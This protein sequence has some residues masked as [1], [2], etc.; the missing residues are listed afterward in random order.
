MTTPKFHRPITETALKY[1]IAAFIL[2]FADPTIAS[3]RHSSSTTAANA[4]NVLNKAIT[5][6]GLVTVRS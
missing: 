4:F 3:R 6:T 5:A 1:A 2:A